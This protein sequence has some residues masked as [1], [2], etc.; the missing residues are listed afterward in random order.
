MSER[1]HGVVLPDEYRELAIANGIS[2]KTV[3]ARI[4]RGWEV[5]KAV[6]VLPTKIT[7][8]HTN[9]RE[10]GWIVSGNRAKGSPITF[11]MYKDSEDLFNEAVNESGLSRSDFVANA[12][13]QYLLKLWKSKTPK[14]NLSKI[15]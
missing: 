6:T 1:K 8:A 14:K 10:E 13:E 15:K 11:T 12:V 4:K 7:S 5:N 3:Y 2:I 9:K